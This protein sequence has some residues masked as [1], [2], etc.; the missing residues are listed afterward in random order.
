MS[1]SEDVL[2]L[3]FLHASLEEGRKHGGGLCSSILI[4]MSAKDQKCLKDSHLHPCL[5]GKY[6]SN[7]SVFMQRILTSGVYIWG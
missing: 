1:E 7:D 3:R 2:T 4:N 5:R 6:S